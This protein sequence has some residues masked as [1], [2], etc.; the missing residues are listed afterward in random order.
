MI[1]AVSVGLLVGFFG[2]PD[3]RFVAGST[4]SPR[5]FDSAK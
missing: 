2:L 4:S 5:L 3:A 1:L